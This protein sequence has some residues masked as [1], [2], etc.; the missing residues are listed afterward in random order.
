MDSVMNDMIQGEMDLSM[1]MME[2]IIDDDIDL[3]A[4]LIF[5]FHS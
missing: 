3:Y 4:S 1:L 2:M 5:M